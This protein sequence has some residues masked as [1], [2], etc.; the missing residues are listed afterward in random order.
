MAVEFRFAN[1]GEYPRISDFLNEHWAKNHIYTR[2]RPLFDWS[3]HRPGHWDPEQLQLL[4]G[5]GRPAN[6]WEFLAAF[7]SRST[8]SGSLRKRCGS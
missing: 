5:I 4:A 6:F 7:R 8:V 3:F 2:N 1:L